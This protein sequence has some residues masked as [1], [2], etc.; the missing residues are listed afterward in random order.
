MPDINPLYSPNHPPLLKTVP[1]GE[2]L[3]NRVVSG[4]PEDSRGLFAVDPWYWLRCA[5]GQPAIV[6]G[7]LYMGIS[8]PQRGLILNPD[9]PRPY[10]NIAERV[11]ITGQIR[12]TPE[13][14][15]AE[16]PATY[17]THREIEITE[18]FST[19]LSTLQS[20]EET[21]EASVE[22]TASAS[23]FGMEASVTT[24]LRSTVTTG[25]ETQKS[26]ST[27]RE[28]KIKETIDADTT[29][30][31]WLNYDKIEITYGA[32]IVGQWAP[33]SHD[34][35]A[36][37]NPGVETFYVLK[38]VREDRCPTANLPGG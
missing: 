34:Q 22:A 37:I 5:G 35:M 9:G 11:V 24:G 19:E 14:H 18:S 27:F 12:I 32:D 38:E 36:A 26:I 16:R 29:Y 15:L 4:A 7:S 17:N 31:T 21:L 10:V 23:G 28:T 3:H 1:T 30:A 13:W 25:I 20:F 6:A 8:T 33:L 2:I